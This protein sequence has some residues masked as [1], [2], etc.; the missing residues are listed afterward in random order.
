MTPTVVDYW[1]LIWRRKWWVGAA[2]VVTAVTAFGVGSLLPKVYSAQTTILAPKDSEMRGMSSIGASL[3]SLGGGREGG[4]GFLSLP[5]ISLGLPSGTKN[6]EMFLA[7]LASR[8]L[9]EEVLA[10]LAG[11][12]GPSVSSRVLTVE[13][14]SRSRGTLGLVVE[15][16]DPKLAA[17]AANTY[18][19]VLDRRLQRNAAQTGKRREALYRLQL[20]KAS[21]EVAA[22]EEALVEFQT[23]NRVPPV[24]LTGSAQGPKEIGAVVGLRSAIM[25]LETQREVMRLR[26]TDR[27]PQ[28]HEIDKQIAELKQQYSQNLFGSAMDLPPEG[29]NAKGARKECFIAAANMTPVQFALLRLYRNLKIQE[30][31][32][33]S[34]LQGLEQIQYEGVGSPINVELLDPAV[35]PTSPVRPNLRLIVPV[36]GVGG[37]VLGIFTLLFVEYVALVRDERPTKVAGARRGNGAGPPSAPGGDDTRVP[38]AAP[39][40]SPASAPSASRTGTPR[41]VL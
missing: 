27:H 25:A 36:A 26:Y 10:K 33:M 6:E 11:A 30:A 31:F 9:K 2:S 41:P 14:S 4:G 29:P 32:Y 23:K 28:I 1:R 24:D 17:D 12:W 39:R 38:A 37:L 13:T 7:L 21:K 35:V 22:A 40:G 18:F 3:A 34:A 15:A 20:D 5:G 19:D 8:T 16:T